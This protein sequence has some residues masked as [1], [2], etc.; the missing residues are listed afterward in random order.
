MLREHGRF[1]LWTSLAALA[2]R[3]FFFAYTPS[4]VDDSHVYARIASTWLEHGIYGQP[5]GDRIVPTDSRLPG[6]PAFLAVIFWVFGVGNFRA[7]LL[8]QVL[9]DIVT[10]F[11]IAD[12]ARRT[13]SARWAGPAAFA[14]AATCPFLANY[15]A[16]VLTESL[17]IFFIALA[18]DC[19]VA[20]LERMRADGEEGSAEKN[21]KPWPFWAATGAAVGMCILLRPDG[22]I[23]LVAIGLY[24]GVAMVRTVNRKRAGSIAAAGVVVALIALTPLVPWTIRNYRTLHHFQPLAPRYATD[25]D[26]LAPVGFNRWAKTWIAEYVSV[27]EIYWNVPGDE[28]DVAKLPARALDEPPTRSE[29][30][31]VIADYNKTQDLTPELDARFGELAN[32]R[33]RARPFRYYVVLPALRILDMWLR[34]RTE[35]LPPDPRWWEFNDE[36]RES[37]LTVGFGVLNLFYVVAAGVALFGKRSSLWFIGL[38]GGFVLLRSL[39]LGT[40]ENPEPRYTLECFPVLLVWAAACLTVTNKWLLKATAPPSVPIMG[41]KYRIT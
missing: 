36:R 37:A 21:S 39:F 28:I 38:L 27:Q 20:G 34:P 8:V 19:A 17:E 12:L 29:T 18:L 3:L 2:L 15:A 4:I 7:V 1:F 14:L 11:L 35:L 9:L 10:C 16:A 5:E 32:E 40:L 23:L 41:E 30:L 6:Y 22:G 31:A 33:I 26:E 25:T 24:L 13:V